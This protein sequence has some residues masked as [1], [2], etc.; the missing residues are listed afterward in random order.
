MNRFVIADPQKCIGCFTCEVACVMAHN[1]DRPGALN[2]DNFLPRLKVMKEWN[3]ST[4]VLCRQCEDAPCA[5]ACP[6]GAIIHAEDSIQVLQEKCIGCKTC[7]VACPY[8][9]MDIVTRH[10]YDERYPLS[11]QSVKAEAQKC[12]LCAGRAEG[13]ACVNVCPTD[14]LVLMTHETVEMMKLKKRQRAALEGFGA[15]LS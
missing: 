12:D 5:N 8:G 13:Q 2:H 4:P 10:V 11:G 6:N 9:A 1:G 15:V 14:A 7:A 3:I